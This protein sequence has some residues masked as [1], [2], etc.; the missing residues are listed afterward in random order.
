ML[1]IVNL[2]KKYGNFTAVDN[3]NLELEKGDIYGFVGPNGAGKTTT[4]R[5]AATLLE[6][7]S[8]GSGGRINVAEQPVRVRGES[9]ICPTSLVYTII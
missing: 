5:I 1:K 6:A 2:V 4:M 8:D 3:L 7:T 9:D